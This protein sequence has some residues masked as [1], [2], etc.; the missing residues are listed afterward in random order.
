L[1]GQ[2]EVQKGTERGTERYRERYRK[3][4]RDSVVYSIVWDRNNCSSPV[5]ASKPRDEAGAG[6]LLHIVYLSVRMVVYVG[7][8][9]GGVLRS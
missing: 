3:V 8:L 1:N 6:V 5:E 4:Q 9:I 2:R 7:Q